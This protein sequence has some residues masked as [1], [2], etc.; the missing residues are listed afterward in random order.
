MIL[1]YADH[2]YIDIDKIVVMREVEDDMLTNTYN[3]QIVIGGQKIWVTKDEFY[4]ILPTFEKM[5]A[6]LTYNLDGTK[7]QY[8]Y[9]NWRGTDNA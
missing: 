6:H 2:N 4:N 8:D 3:Y 1:K 9:E 5:I 7:I